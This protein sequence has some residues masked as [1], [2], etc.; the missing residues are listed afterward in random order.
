MRLKPIRNRKIWSLAITLLERYNVI[1]LTKHDISK[2]SL[3]VRDELK[4]YIFDNQTPAVALEVNEISPNIALDFTD[5]V[6]LS[7]GGVEEFM[8]GCAQQTIDGMRVFAIHGP[9]IRAE[10]LNEA[11]IENYA[12]FQ[13]RVTKR[14]R[15][16]TGERDKFLFSWDDWTEHESGVGYYAVT[17]ETL[18]SLRIYF[19]MDL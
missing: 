5:V 6:S 9:V 1:T 10:M 2:L 3:A 12:H 13:S 4:A 15:T 8:D 14:T 19:R 16:V 7:P 11:G 18:R 17:S